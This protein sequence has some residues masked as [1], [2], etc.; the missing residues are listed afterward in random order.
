MASSASRTCVSSSATYAFDSAPAPRSFG[1][2]GRAGAYSRQAAQ[3]R[4]TF[5]L[6]GRRLHFFVCRWVCPGRGPPLNPVGLGAG[7]LGRM[8]CRIADADG[9]IWP[10]PA[11]ARVGPSRPVSEFPAHRGRVHDQRQPAA[12]AIANDQAEPRRAAPPRRFNRCPR[13][14]DCFAAD[15]HGRPPRPVCP[16]VLFGRCLR[17]LSAACAEQDIDRTHAAW[18]IGRARWRAEALLGDIAEWFDTCVKGRGRAEAGGST[19]PGFPNPGAVGSSPAGDAKQNPKVGKHASRELGEF[20]PIEFV[21]SVRQPRAIREE[22]AA[23]PM[24]VRRTVNH[25][26]S[27][28]ASTNRAQ[29]SLQLST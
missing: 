6:A 22:T 20:R 13:D 11:G 16:H 5:A 21:S 27:A 18:S 25:E 24:P 12:A 17:S 15:F 4:R 29:L 10:A 9:A 2:R 23:S 28:G 14:P 1:R 26:Y 19:C 7:I 8:R 3:G